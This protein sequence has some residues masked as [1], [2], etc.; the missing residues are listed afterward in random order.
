MQ[1]FCLPTC[2]TH[3]GNPVTHICFQNKAEYVCQI[4]LTKSDC[5]SGH[6]KYVME[7]SDFIS[8]AEEAATAVEQMESSTIARH[9]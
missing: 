5:C 2:K 7:I 6:L 3:K 1:T 8:N 9:A 4:C